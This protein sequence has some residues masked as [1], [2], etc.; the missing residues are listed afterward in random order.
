MWINTDDKYFGL[1]E[2]QAHVNFSKLDGQMK[3]VLDSLPNL[4]IP[5]QQVI[6]TYGNAFL[7]AFAEVYT[8]QNDQ[9]LPYLSSTYANY[10]SRDPNALHLVKSEAE[11]P[12][13]ELFNRRKTSRVSAIY[14]RNNFPSND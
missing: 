8:A 14:P 3:A 5:N 2:G 7:V 12:L 1:V 4:T 13:S 6:D 10:V 9:F 11:V